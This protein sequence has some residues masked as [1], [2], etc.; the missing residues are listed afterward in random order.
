MS[1]AAYVV[2]GWLLGILSPLITRYMERTRRKKEIG[3]GLRAELSELRVRLA[4]AC[5]LVTLRYDEFDRAFLT[6]LKP[7]L[8]RYEG[9]HPAQTIVDTLEKV[10]VFPD[11]EIASFAALDRAKTDKSLSL[12]KYRLPYLEANLGNLDLFSERTKLLLMET[13][14]QTETINEEIEQIRFYYGLTFDSGLSEE[15]HKRARHSLA[16]SSRNV[17]KTGREVLNRLLELENTLGP[18]QL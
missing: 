9:S 5:F 10:L 11:H 14:A 16:E 4:I 3:E 7:L 17:A 2:L 15:N 6:W 1:E 18:E 12:K 8:E 13:A